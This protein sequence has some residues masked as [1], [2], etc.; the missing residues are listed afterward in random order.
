MHFKLVNH[1]P[2]TFVIVFD[3]GEEV[4]K[5]LEEFCIDESVGAAAFK[6]IGAFSRAVVG[7]FELATKKYKDIPVNEQVEVLS[8]I[9]DVTLYKD[10][11]R[12]HAH[13]VLGRS[14]GSTCG[15]HLLSAIVKPTLEV[16][17]TELPAYLHREMNRDFG[18]P[19]IKIDDGF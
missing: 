6:A 8:L 5:T 10:Q 16:V 15:G 4:V 1:E 2:R 11:P 3:V 18:I 7:Y 19:L 12:L 17:I 9:G 14:D 13:V